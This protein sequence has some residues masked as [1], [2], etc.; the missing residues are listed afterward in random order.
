M[1][2]GPVL[3][4]LKAKLFEQIK[5]L[6]HDLDTVSLYFGRDGLV[7]CQN[8]HPKRHHKSA[9]R[10]RVWGRERLAES[11]EGIHWVASESD[12][13]VINYLWQRNVSLQAECCVL[14]GTRLIAKCQT[15]FDLQW[16]TARYALLGKETR[17][18]FDS[19]HFFH[20][21]FLE[22]FVWLNIGIF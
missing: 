14:N 19:F 9:D 6:P 20:L 8:S 16:T 2:P 17:S 10:V 5:C 3:Y 1:K 18:P 4:Y 7:F 21:S 13:R 22:W 15:Q 12:S 11:T